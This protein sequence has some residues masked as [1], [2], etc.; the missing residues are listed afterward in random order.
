V[1]SEGLYNFEC[2]LKEKEYKVTD[3]KLGTKCNFKALHTLIH[4]IFITTP[5]NT[6]I[7]YISQME[8]TEF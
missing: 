4:V 1:K 3:T 6:V 2:P 7:I 8:K 5:L